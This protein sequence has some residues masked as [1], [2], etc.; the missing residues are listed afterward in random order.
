MKKIS[1]LKER[2]KEKKCLVNLTIPLVEETSFFFLFHCERSFLFHAKDELD[3]ISLAK[4]LMSFLHA[5]LL[6]LKHKVWVTESV[7]LK[8]FYL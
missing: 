7:F 4:A 1:N 6:I 3:H 8:V 2:K 5:L